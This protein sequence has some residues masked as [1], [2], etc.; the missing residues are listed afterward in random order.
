MTQRLKHAIA[1]AQEL[2]QDFQDRLASLL[3]QE[4]EQ[5][6]GAPSRHEAT[7]NM[8]DLAE[9]LGQTIP[10]EAWNALPTDLAE[11]HDSYLYGPS[12]KRP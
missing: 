4:I 7:T 6:D 10:E 12:K 8:W 3:L 1:R 11:K 2:P 9:Q 5:A